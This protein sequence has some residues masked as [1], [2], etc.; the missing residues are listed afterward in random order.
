MAEALR[1]RNA[2]V[3]ED[4]NTRLRESRRATQGSPLRRRTVGG[5]RNIAQ[6][7]CSAEVRVFCGLLRSSLVACQD[8]R[9]ESKSR[10]VLRKKNSALQDYR[11]QLSRGHV[12]RSPELADA[13][14]DLLFAAL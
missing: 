6:E 4:R 5:L 14:D 10:R 3:R 1:A 9:L 7:L 11:T 2:R 8:D 12:L 13:G